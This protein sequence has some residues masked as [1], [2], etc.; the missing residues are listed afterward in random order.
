MKQHALRDNFDTTLDVESLTS[1]ED[2]GAVWRLST[3]PSGCRLMQL[4]VAK[5]PLA[6]L[7]SGVVVAS[8]PCNSLTTIGQLCR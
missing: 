3:D 5:V 8:N 1:V 7:L 4:A 6:V 2:A